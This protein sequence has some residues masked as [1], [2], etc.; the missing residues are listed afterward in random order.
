MSRWFWLLLAVTLVVYLLIVLWSLPI[1]QAEADGLVPFD[2]R[3][4]GYTVADAQT[5][6]R[7]LTPEGL[8]QYEGPQRWLD[9]VFP[10]LLVGVLAWTVWHLTQ[11]TPEWVRLVLWL[12]IGV[13]AS[14]DYLE[15]LHVAQMLAAG[16]EGVTTALVEAASRASSQK[17][18]TTTVAV[19]GILG[20]LIRRWR[21]KRRDRSQ[22]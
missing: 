22:P 5:F 12:L 18:L 19:F 14:F 4:G 8:A 6:L 2:L 9:W 17:A 15:N 16:A 13:G 20:L 1:I 11:E 10:L 3:A 21:E 7:A